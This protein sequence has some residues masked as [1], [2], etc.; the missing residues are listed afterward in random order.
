MKPKQNY[1]LGL[2][3]I[4]DVL[5]KLIEIIY[6]NQ[7]ELSAIHRALDEADP[8]FRERYEKHFAAVTQEISD[9]KDSALHLME[10]TAGQLRGDPYWA[11]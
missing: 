7:T 6:N 10:R 4:L 2:A 9:A 5:R 8:T 3:A 11:D 1:A